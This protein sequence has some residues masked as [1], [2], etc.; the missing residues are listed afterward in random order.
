MTIKGEKYDGFAEEAGH[1]VHSPGDPPLVSSIIPCFNEEKYIGTILTNIVSQD[2]PLECLE[3]IVVDGMSTDGTRSVVQSFEKQH[4]FIHLADN[5]RRF[6][7]FALNIGIDKSGGE[8]IMIMGSHSVY[9][10]NYVSVLVKALFELDADNVGGVC[11]T[12]PPTAT[13]RAKAIAEVISS[14]FGVGNSYFRIGAKERMKVDTVTF[15]CYRRSV[16]ERIGKFDEDLLRNQDDEFN[17][18]LIRNGGSIYLIPE[19]RLV[20]YSREKI[21]S[22]LKMFYQYGLFKPLVSLKNGKPATIRQLVPFVFL[23]FILGGLPL[24][25][26]NPVLGLG[27]VGVTGLYFLLDLLFSFR[28]CRTQRSPALF[29]ILP[30]LFFALHLS[31]GTGYLAGLVNFV[32]LKKKK[33]QIHSSR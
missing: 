22:L 21:G 10:L 15:G 16:F 24:A 12:Q 27:Y 8:V 4:R 6:V 11:D 2:Y 30:W 29:L 20:Y 17:S 9:P 28:I 13:L 18:R 19:V 26:M 31:Y 5:E 25:L 23:L 1:T 7:P 32:I 3:V 33:T 14:P